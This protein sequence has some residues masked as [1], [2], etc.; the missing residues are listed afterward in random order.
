MTL[1]NQEGE[2]STPSVVLFDG[3][4]PIVGTEALQN[5]IRFPDRVIENS[6]RYMG[7]VGKRWWINDRPY[8]PVDV[9]ALILKKLLSAAEQK[10]GP[11]THAVITVPAQFSDSHAR[12]RPGRSRSR[13]RRVDV[14]NEPVAAALCYVLGSRGCGFPRARRRA[15][16]P[17]VRPW[18]RDVRP[19]ARSLPQK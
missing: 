8:A 18:R 13:A 3:E 1:P 12:H 11:I 19:V 10:I 5:S 17:R 7:D 9:A 4:R 2:L 14:I 15:A 16:D 6:K